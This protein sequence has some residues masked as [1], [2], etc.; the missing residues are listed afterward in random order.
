M[1]S[2]PINFKIGFLEIPSHLVFYLLAIYVGFQYYLYLGNKKGDFIEEKYRWYL[3]IGAVLGA[4]IFSKLLAALETPDLFFNPSSLLFY[5]QGQTIVGGLLGGYLGVEVVKKILKEKRATGNLFT[6][7][8][9][10]GIGIGRIGCL[11]TGVSDRTVGIESS[12]PWAFEQGDGIP[13]HPTSLY[14][15]IFLG[16]LFYFL[17]SVEKRKSLKNGVL[18]KIFMFSYL[19]FRFLIEFIKPINPIFLGLSAIQFAS[20]LGSLYFATL[21]I[22]VQL[23]NG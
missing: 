10:L 8:L 9:I 16:L 15:I 18:F 19:L 4:L 23:K 6:Y 14:E 17:K 20:L 2:F 5:I 22:K 1:V 11:L 21:I 3:I 7:P 13:R 12:L